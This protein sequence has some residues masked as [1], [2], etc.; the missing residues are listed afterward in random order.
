MWLNSVS[1]VVFLKH[2][3]HSCCNLGKTASSVW[4][5]GGKDPVG[6]LHF[7]TAEQTAG[8]G[9]VLL[10][11]SANLSWSCV[12]RTY[13][14]LSHVFVSPLHKSLNKRCNQIWTWVSSHSP[15]L[16]CLGAC[17]FIGSFDIFFCL[18]YLMLVWLLLVNGWHE[19][20]ADE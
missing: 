3:I 17:F 19:H 4:L 20:Y 11:C 1:A 12:E 14:W 10:P 18:W 9:C 5:E 7:P 6:I 8:E 2:R 16:P 13:G 15:A